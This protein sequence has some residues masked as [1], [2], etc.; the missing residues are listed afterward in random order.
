MDFEIQEEREVYWAST[1]QYKMKFE[2]GT[3]ME[4]RAAEDSNGTDFYVPNWIVTGKL[5]VLLEF[6]NPL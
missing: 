3:V 6:Q 2:D 1:N 4:F 5:R